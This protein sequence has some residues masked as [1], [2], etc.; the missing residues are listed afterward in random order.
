MGKKITDEDRVIDRK[1][2]LIG[3]EKSKGKRRTKSKY[4]PY[5]WGFKEAKI[6]ALKEI[7]KIGK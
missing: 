3:T 6:R 7:K 1:N 2:A 5:S 4:G